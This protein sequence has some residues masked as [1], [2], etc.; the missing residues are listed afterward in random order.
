MS[1]LE[2]LLLIHM[3]SLKCEMPVA[4]YRF[5]PVRRWRF[6]FAYPSQKLAIEVEGGTWTNGRH[7]RAKGFESDCEK[8]NTAQMMGWTVLRFT[9]DMI[10]RGEAI[11]SIEAALLAEEESGC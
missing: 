10:K 9:G 2:K 5:H 6:D 11:Q 4:E 7:S 8:Y 3:R 1:H